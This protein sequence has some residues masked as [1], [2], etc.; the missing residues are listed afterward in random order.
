MRGIALHRT[1]SWLPHHLTLANRQPHKTTPRTPACTQPHRTRWQRHTSCRRASSS[2]RCPFSAR[3][4]PV[5]FEARGWRRTATHTHLLPATLAPHACGRRPPPRR[6]F[7]LSHSPRFS[8]CWFSPP[9]VFVS[10]LRGDPAREGPRLHC[11]AATH[12]QSKTHT[13][14]RTPDTHKSQHLTATTTLAA[15][16]RVIATM[17]PCPPAALGATSCFESRCSPR[18]ATAP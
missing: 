8:L 10:P 3:A 7:D 13:R 11:A 17:P 9:C 5:L 14:T 6:S 1:Y 15:A 12:H 4:T 16:P 2:P 18:S